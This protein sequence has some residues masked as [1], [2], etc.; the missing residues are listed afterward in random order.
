MRKTGSLLQK[1]GVRDLFCSEVSSFLVFKSILRKKHRTKES[2]LN[3]AAEF[4]RNI[5]L[6]LSHSKY[7]DSP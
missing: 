2:E 6:F 1:F 3:L 5:S 7:T 4:P